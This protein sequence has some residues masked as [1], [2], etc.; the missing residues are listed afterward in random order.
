MQM[1][2]I[3]D[4]GITLVTRIRLLRENP[5]IVHSVMSEI[6]GRYRTTKNESDLD[7]VRTVVKN[8][9]L[10]TATVLAIVD[11]FRVVDLELTKRA[12][13]SNIHEAVRTTLYL[14]A[15]IR[16]YFW[17]D[18]PLDHLKANIAGAISGIPLGDREAEQ[19]Y[20]DVVYITNPE[21]RLFGDRKKAVSL[22]IYVTKY[23]FE[24]YTILGNAPY[25][26]FMYIDVCFD[27][28][29]ES[30]ALLK[31]FMEWIPVQPGRHKVDLIWRLNTYIHRAKRRNEYMKEFIELDEM[32]RVID[33]GKKLQSP[34]RKFHRDRQNVHRIK[35]EKDTLVELDK[36]EAKFKDREDDSMEDLYE[37]P[38]LRTTLERIDSD[39]SDFYGSTLKQ[40]LRIVFLWA[41]DENHLSILEQEL[42]DMKGM[43]TSGHFRR[44]VN[45][46]NGF[47]FHLEESTHEKLRDEFFSRTNALIQAQ[48]NADE[49]VCDLSTRGV[50]YANEVA[51]ELMKRMLDWYEVMRV[52]RLYLYG[53]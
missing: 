8:M 53:E 42:Q 11:V 37:K 49:I 6:A 7:F 21:C 13:L 30:H 46:M 16:D 52:R 12:L 34:L 2:R 51:L 3:L 4:T 48:P 10:P 32:L 22:A 41:K 36:M 38:E 18:L 25:H 28:G 40:W 14:V 47:V 26:A 9:N 5:S 1:E 15:Y 31:T 24:R 27:L 23:I 45:V 17:A 44:L 35:I 43:C 19:K 39:T 50:R 29:K 20:L 33:L